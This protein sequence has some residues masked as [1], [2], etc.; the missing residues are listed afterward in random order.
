MSNLLIRDVDHDIVY[1]KACTIPDSPCA[2]DL[3]SILRSPVV[4]VFK[5]IGTSAYRY[6][7]LCLPSSSESAKG[8]CYSIYGFCDQFGR[9]GIP[10]RT[11]FSLQA[12][13]VRWLGIEPNWTIWQ[14]KVFGYSY[15][16][17]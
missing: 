4:S 6:L 9:S 2:E 12:T 16:K 13:V 1:F 15:N 8:C 14:K 11:V 10:A 17:L 7:I 3:K 5:V